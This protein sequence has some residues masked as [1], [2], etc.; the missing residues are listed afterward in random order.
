[1][2]VVL[3]ALAV[4]LF[5]EFVIDQMGPPV[6]FF[7][8][9]HGRPLERGER[10]GHKER[11]TGCDLA[12]S[13][14]VFLRDLVISACHP[15]GQARDLFHIL[16]RLC[17]ESQH[18]VKFDLGPTAFKGLSCTRQ[19]LFF[20]QPLVDHIPHPLGAGLR[21]ESQAALAD[22]LNLAHDIQGKGVDTKG[23]KGNVDP[24]VFELFDQE[25]DKVIQFRVVAGA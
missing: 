24:P 7:R 2:P 9:I 16:F 19:D 22:I 14:P 15:V 21:S 8:R 17:G 20:C 10:F 11:G 18:E 4:Q 1:M 5:A 6:I 25:C 13:V 3:Q 23:R 12:F